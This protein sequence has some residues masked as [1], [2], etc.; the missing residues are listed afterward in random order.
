M[1]DPDPGGTW[2]TSTPAIAFAGAGTGLITGVS[3]GPVNVIYTFTS[4]GCR[5]TTPFTV[6]PLPAAISGT[7]LGVCIG[8][9]ATLTDATPGGTFSGGA[10]RAS[11]TL[12]GLV[13]GFSLGPA[14]ITYTAPS[15]CAITSS[16]MVNPLP[17]PIVGPSVVC[18]SATITLTDPDAGGTW[19][20][21][22]ATIA[23]AFP[24]TGVVTGHTVGSVDI[25]Y[26]FPATGCAAVMNVT[27]NSGPGAIAG[28][29]GPIILC[30]GDSI[31]LNGS[32]LLFGPFT[33]QW[34]DSGS[35]I[36][37][38]T[39]ASF[40]ASRTGSYSVFVTNTLGCT[41]QSGVIDVTAGI[42]PVITHA[43]PLG[44]CIGNSVVLT[45]DVGGATGVI[46]YQWNKGGLAIAGETNVTY[47]A[48]STGGYTVEVT[49]NGLST[50]CSATTPV[51]TVVVDNFPTP[52][53]SYTGTMLKTSN[54][55][56]TYQWFLNSVAIPGATNYTYV[57]V[58]DGSYRVRVGDIIGCPGF[59]SAYGIGGV[60]TPLITAGGLSIFPNPVNDVLHIVSPVKL[61][62]VITGL[63]GR[64]IIEQANAQ[65]IDMTK[66]AKGIYM[67]NLFDDH[68]TRVHVQKLVKE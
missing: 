10:P 25:S 53:I 47:T 45:A 19:S 52:S 3:A 8:G 1:T 42:A 68:G 24:T 50:S 48:D 58:A 2:S 29:A 9:T 57:P 56:V 16:M 67:L 15:G 66:L 21:F 28:P 61:R 38:A 59:S 11:V 41:L 35:T 26:T 12:G 4:T 39:N 62:A 18:Q 33:F 5:I 22:D 30:T 40:N 14:T 54:T 46:A 27:V 34:D 63:E 44:F 43:T 64:T 60:G 6:D 36:P 23:D 37:G 13:S 20:S 65:E 49:V 32:G 55:Y 51:A 17:R 7:A 31:L